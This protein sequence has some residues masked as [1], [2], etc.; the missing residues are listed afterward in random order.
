MSELLLDISHMREARARVDRTYGADAVPS[1]DEVYRVVDPIV[2]AA[3]VQRD[4]DQF[5]LVGSVKTAIELTCGRCLEKFR[6]P[7]HESFDVLYLPHAAAP[8]DEETEVAD[9]D[10][11]T[12]FYREGMLYSRY[13]HQKV[14][15]KLSHGGI[16]RLQGLSQGAQEPL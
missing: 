9:D 12:A 5:R 2:L 14:L 10:L 8:G 13:I 4:R 1:D 15:R 11:T 16:P 3:D 6:A 7:V